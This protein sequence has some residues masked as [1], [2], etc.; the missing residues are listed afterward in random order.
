VR[1]IETVEPVCLYR[2]NRPGLT[3]EW[4][5]EAR[6]QCPN[7]VTIIVMDKELVNSSKITV[8]L[9]PEGGGQVSLGVWSDL[10]EWSTERPL[11]VK[12][13]LALWPGYTV[14]CSLG[15]GI[16]YLRRTAKIPVDEL[17]A[18]VDQGEY[19]QAQYN[20][21]QDEQMLYEQEQHEY[22]QHEHALYDQEQYEY[23]QYEH[24]QYEHEHHD[25]L[26]IPP[27]PE[28][29]PG[30][31]VTHDDPLEIDDDHSD[32]LAAM[33]PSDYMTDL[34]PVHWDD[35]E[36]ENE[37][38]ENDEEDQWEEDQWWAGYSEA[39][40][41]PIAQE[42]LDKLIQVIRVDKRIDRIDF[43]SD[44]VT[45]EL[46][47]DICRARIDTHG[48]PMDTVIAKSLEPF[49]TSD[50]ADF[51][52]RATGL[53]HLQL[54]LDLSPSSVQRFAGYPITLSSLRSI[55][56]VVDTS[57]PYLSSLSLN[58][59]GCR[60]ADESPIEEQDMPVSDHPF[61]GKLERI[62][63]VVEEKYFRNVNAPYYSPCV[64]DLIPWFAI[65][66]NLACLGSKGCVYRV[67]CGITDVDVS[68]YS[69]AIGEIIK[70]Y[71][72]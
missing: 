70:W 62:D 13:A 59:K 30:H 66:K 20:Q 26:A 69:R 50:L 41:R 14:T 45:L 42:T 71:R 11:E 64:P 38:E 18:R 9:Y 65:A 15:I 28:A 21:D 54:W 63:V 3:Y 17:P 68:E 39:I 19:N 12:Q 27:G 60:T 33:D 7:L 46:L 5:E 57:F 56:Q 34:N 4:V 44:L 61:E 37:F 72:G 10:A 1:T 32:E 24:E 35:Q 31:Q 67:S 25:G 22:A 6:R 29:N 2:K 49:S 16:G 47:G 53:R 43:G 40:T 48:V 36:H 52:A 58:L 23:E 51:G 8:H 55:V